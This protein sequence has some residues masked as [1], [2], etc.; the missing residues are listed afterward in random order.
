MSNREE[1]TDDAV[2]VNR[3]LRLLG[4]GLIIELAERESVIEMKVTSPDLKDPAADIYARARLQEIVKD[5]YCDACLDYEIA[6]E[7]NRHAD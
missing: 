3:L 6:G 4:S 7:A 1:L 5:K 2:L